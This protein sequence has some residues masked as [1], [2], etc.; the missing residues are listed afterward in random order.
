MGCHFIFFRLGGVSQYLSATG[1]KH[2]STVDG[3]FG[4]DGGSIH[5]QND[6]KE[7]ELN[8]KAALILVKMKL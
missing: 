8:M 6:H 3:D 7:Q 1:V 4:E 5:P 2:P